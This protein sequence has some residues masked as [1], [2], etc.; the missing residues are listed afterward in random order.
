MA[1]TSVNPATSEIIATYDQMDPDRVNEVLAAASGAQREWR[2]APFNDRSQ[3]LRRAGDLLRERVDSYARLMTTEMGKPLG[4]A[5]A[6]VEKCAWV[7][8]YY[9]EHAARFLVS[10][11]VEIDTGEAIVSYQPLGVVLA[12]MPW[13]FPFWQVLRFAAPTLMAGNGGLLK[14]AETTMGCALAIERLLLDAGLP[15]GVFTA[16]LIT[17]DQ[18]AQVIDSEHVQAVTLTGSTRAGR[19]VAQAAGRALKKTVLELG[20][21]DP[22]V[23]LA[24]ADLDRAADVC[25]TSRLINSGQ[26]CIAAKRFIVVEARA[27]EFTGS[28][29]ARMAAADFGDPLHD[30]P[31]GPLARLDLR[32][33]LHRQVEQSVRAGARCPLGGSVPEGPGAFYPATV[34]T[35]VKP[36][37]PAY[38]EEVFGPVASIIVAKDD[39]DAIRIA[40]DTAYGLGAAVFTTDA[41][42]GRHIAEKRLEAGA[43]FVNDF[44]ASD[45]RLPFGG[46][47]GSGYGRELGR[48]GIREF[49]NV[50]TV[51]VR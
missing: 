19:A 21:S 22:Y 5:R 25:A 8:E 12:I 37:M 1:F 30:P 10:D 44:V 2:S 24:D 26:S 14:H 47:K 41:T 42:R 51:V 35:N 48:P 43:C 20:G 28:V 49:V 3:V 36:G 29:T 11:P 46:I 6:E 17:H 34:L 50:K 13:N 38:D 39:E 4:Q 9:A 7:C 31:L 32:D 23:V 15:D 16:L 40:N 45:P 33:T 27:E 18:A